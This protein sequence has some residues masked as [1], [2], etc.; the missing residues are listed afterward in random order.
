MQSPEEIHYNDKMLSDTGIHHNH[1]C[2]ACARILNLDR[3]A[4]DFPRIFMQ[5]EHNG[6]ETK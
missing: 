6:G 1:D 4:H 2:H 3:S 5:R